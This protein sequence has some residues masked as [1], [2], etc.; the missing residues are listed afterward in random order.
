MKGSEGRAPVLAHAQAPGPPSRETQVQLCPHGGATLHGQQGLTIVPTSHR[1]QQL[2][3]QPGQSMK[4]A[5]T[6]L[7]PS[8]LHRNQPVS[9]GC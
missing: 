9:W 2:T 5:S 8:Q 4:P 3:P 7:T 6:K 1:T